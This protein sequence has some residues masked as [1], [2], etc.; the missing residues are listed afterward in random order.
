MPVIL[1]LTSMF[2]SLMDKKSVSTAQMTCIMQKISLLSRTDVNIKLWFASL[3]R[4]F[5]LK[6]V[7]NRGP[8]GFN[9]ILQTDTYPKRPAKCA[10]ALLTASRPPG[11]D[12]HPAICAVKNDAHLSGS[13]GSKQDSPMW[14]IATYWYQQ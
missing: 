14:A 12:L 9:Y 6:P 13:D 3:S 10:L 8:S 5:I 11:E 1:S 2:A 4:H 7:T